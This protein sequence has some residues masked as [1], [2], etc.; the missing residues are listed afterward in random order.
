MAKYI[1]AEKLIDI[2]NA[3][4][5]MA[6]GTPKAV[7]YNAAKIVDTLP[8]A[9]V[10]EVKHGHWGKSFDNGAQMHECSVCGARVVKGVY[11]YENPNKYCYRCGAKMDGERRTDNE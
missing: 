8:A 4:G 10:V 6:T 5:D 7:F 2:F 11:E 9:D 1:E 3:K